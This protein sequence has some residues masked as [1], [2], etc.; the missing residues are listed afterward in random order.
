[1]CTSGANRRKIGPSIF[2]LTKTW[3]RVARADSGTMKISTR[4]V[5]PRTSFVFGSAQ[6]SVYSTRTG[7]K[8]ATKSF[9]NRSPR[10]VPIRCRSALSRCRP[11]YETTLQSAWFSAWYWIVS[12]WASS[13]PSRVCTQG[14]CSS[15]PKLSSAT[16]SGASNNIEYA[17]AS[18]KPSQ[19]VF[20]NALSGTSRRA[21]QR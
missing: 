4:V 14:V 10:R 8:R 13:Q 9:E 6:D 21:T 3:N 1:L 7:S 2:T 16:C 18:S 15:S 19:L 12:T 17:P 11:V 20:G 5:G